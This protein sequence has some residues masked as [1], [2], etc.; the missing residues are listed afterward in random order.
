[1][2]LVGGKKNMQHKHKV[3]VAQIWNSKKAIQR[4][5]DICD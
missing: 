1:M 3:I 4:E 5:T 2:S